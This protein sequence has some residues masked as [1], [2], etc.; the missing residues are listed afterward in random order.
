MLSPETEDKIQKKYQRLAPYLNELSVRI[1]AAAEAVSHGHGGISSVARATGLSR[2]TIHT[3]IEELEQA[4]SGE[5]SSSLT[6]S[7]RIRRPGGG[8]KS[9][10][11]KQPKGVERP[12]IS[13]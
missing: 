2:T 12:R 9:L 4:E 5:V 11:Q 13:S 8:R 1:W 6:N 7:Q 10:T 3:G